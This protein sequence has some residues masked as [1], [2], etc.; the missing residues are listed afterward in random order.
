[1]SEEAHTLQAKLIRLKQE[2]SEWV[3]FKSV[4]MQTYRNYLLIRLPQR[5]NAKVL[6]VD[7]QVAVKQVS[8]PEDRLRWQGAEIDD[9]EVVMTRRTVDGEDSNIT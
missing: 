2:G 5:E 9:V 3:R 1:M 6:E 7:L 8:I 4:K